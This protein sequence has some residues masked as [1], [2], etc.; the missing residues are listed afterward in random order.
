MRGQWQAFL[1]GLPLIGWF[2]TGILSVA[3]L[4]FVTTF[5]KQVII[6]GLML[7]F[8]GVGTYALVKWILPAVFEKQMSPIA[9]YAP[10][11]AILVIAFIAIGVSGFFLS[12]VGSPVHYSI[13]PL[14]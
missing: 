8:I 10:L 1:I 2:I 11:I 13:V 9:K 6:N 14:G 7:L 12:L 5:L 3:A 4:W